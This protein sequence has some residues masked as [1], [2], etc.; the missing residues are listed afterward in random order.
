MAR[1]EGLQQGAGRGRLRTRACSTLHA[2]WVADSACAGTAHEPGG[3]VAPATFNVAVWCQ[4]PFEGRREV[5]PMKA[6]VGN[7]PGL[8]GL[9]LRAF[10][11]TSASSQGLE[12]EEKSSLPIWV[13]GREDMLENLCPEPER[14]KGRG[15]PEKKSSSS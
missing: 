15:Y 14:E 1:K 5:E 13:E 10:P 7:P 9:L 11:L 3:G 6:L 8:Q 4:D 12:Q 2:R